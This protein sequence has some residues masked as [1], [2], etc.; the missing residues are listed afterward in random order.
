MYDV[1]GEDVTYGY[2]HLVTIS[3]SEVNV[4]NYSKREVYLLL[5]KKGT[6][7]RTFRQGLILALNCK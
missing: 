2:V 5:S 6:L 4:S 3:L 1:I 7:I